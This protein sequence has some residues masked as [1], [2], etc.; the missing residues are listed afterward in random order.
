MSR[1]RGRYSFP[2][3]GESFLLFP[4]VIA[5]LWAIL[6]GLFATVGHVWGPEDERGSWEGVFGAI[7][8]NFVLVFVLSFVVSLIVRLRNRRRQD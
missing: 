6:V 7:G 2:Q 5:G 4:L 1:P 8:G 3:P